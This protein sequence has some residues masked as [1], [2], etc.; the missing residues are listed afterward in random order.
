MEIERGTY[1]VHFC[2]SQK[3]NKPN[4]P[5]SKLQIALW[6]RGLFS[7]QFCPV[8]YGLW[9][10]K[11]N[12][13]RISSTNWKSIGGYHEIEEIY[14]VRRTILDMAASEIC[15]CVNIY[16]MDI[17]RAKATTDQP[18]WWHC[19][20]VT[21]TVRIDKW[22]LETRDGGMDCK[23]TPI[24]IFFAQI[25]AQQQQQDRRLLGRS[26]RGKVLKVLLLGWWCV[27]RFNEQKPTTESAITLSTPRF[28]QFPC[29]DYEASSFSLRWAIQ[30]CFLSTTRSSFPMHRIYYFQ[31]PPS[32]LLGWLGL[33]LQIDETTRATTWTRRRRVRLGDSAC[34]PLLILLTNRR[35]CYLLVLLMFQIE[36]R[37]EHDREEGDMVLTQEQNHKGGIMKWILAYLILT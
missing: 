3:I 26:S 32:L 7:K 2:L 36:W 12:L 34:R 17:Q 23:Y 33:P 11:S 10:W 30:F 8:E 29:V 25:P 1:H 27:V 19:C 5:K 35:R 18:F 24:F 20:R 37:V 6:G 16:D 21:V 28:Y 13:N 15:P 14:S 31:A 4:I 9:L 22:R